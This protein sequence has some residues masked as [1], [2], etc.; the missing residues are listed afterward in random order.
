MGGI[1]VSFNAAGI[2][3]PVQRKSVLLFCGSNGFSQKRQKK[4]L[5]I[6]QMMAVKRAKRGFTF[7]MVS[8]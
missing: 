2:R 4:H 8:R 1:R 6:A 3:R 5:E 7:F